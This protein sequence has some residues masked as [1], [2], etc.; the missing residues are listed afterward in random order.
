V[1]HLVYVSTFLLQYHTVLI[2]IAW[3]YNLKSESLRLS[4]LFFLLKIALTIW[5]LLWLNAYFSIAFLFL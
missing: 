3:Q 4:A 2:T 1:L 5:G